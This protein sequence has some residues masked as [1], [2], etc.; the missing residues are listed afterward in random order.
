MR[1][2]EWGECGRYP[3]SCRVLSAPQQAWDGADLVGVVDLCLL[4]GRGL[5]S[6]AHWQFCLCPGHAGISSQLFY[7]MKICMW[8]KFQGTAAINLLHSLQAK[9]GS[10]RTSLCLPAGKGVLAVQGERPPEGSFP[11]P[12]WNGNSPPSQEAAL[13]R[14]QEAEREPEHKDKEVQPPLQIMKPK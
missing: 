12:E 7:I 11:G 2:C 13:T 14:G 1:T 5:I 9:Q 3:E 10:C 6:V 8:G 4:G